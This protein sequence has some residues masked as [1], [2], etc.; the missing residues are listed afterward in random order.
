MS[1]KKG[2]HL[3]FKKLAEKLE[4]SGKSEKSAKAIAA[5]VGRAKYG[6]TEMAKKAKAGKRTSK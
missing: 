4:K 2:T 1:E 5:S 6:A 3:G